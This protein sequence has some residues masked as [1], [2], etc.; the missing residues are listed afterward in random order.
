MARRAAQQAKKENRKYKQTPVDQSDKDIQGGGG[1]GARG[2]GSERGASQPQ[3]RGRGRPTHREGE[4]PYPR[5][6]DRDRDREYREWDE[7]QSAGP[8]SRREPRSHEEESWQRYQ[9][10]MKVEPEGQYRT[11]PGYFTK[12][13]EEKKRAR[14]PSMRRGERQGRRD[15]SHDRQD[16]RRDYSHERRGRRDYSPERQSRRDY[17]PDYEHGRGRGRGRRYYSPDERDRE[18]RRYSG[19]NR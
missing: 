15:Y 4:R 14:S 11:H 3:Y 19:H 10:Q 8:S 5:Y 7:S 13:Y 12:E 2:R 1:R 16:S 18:G 9:E 6:T 17:S